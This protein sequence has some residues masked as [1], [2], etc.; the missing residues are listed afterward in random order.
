MNRTVVVAVCILFMFAFFV[1]ALILPGGN[2]EP[3]Q[4][5]NWKSAFVIWGTRDYS[6]E[7]YMGAD[8]EKYGSEQV[9]EEV[10]ELVVD[11]G[12]F[13]FSRNFWGRGT[14]PD[15]L[16]G[17]VSYCEQ[18]YNFTAVFYKGHSIGGYC[19]VENCTLGEHWMLYADG[20]YD[21]EW[22]N[23]WQIHESL[24]S[25]TH[26]FVFLW[27]CGY[28]SEERIG[29]IDENGHSVG[30]LTSWM[31]VTGLSGDGYA[32]PDGSSHCFIG[33]DD[34]SIWFTNKTGYN[35]FTYSDFA[36]LFFEYALMEG[37]TVND[38]LDASAEETHLQTSFG[39]CQLYTGYIMPDAENNG[40]PILCYMRVLGDGNLKLQKDDANSASLPIEENSAEKV[41]TYLQDVVGLDVPA[42]NTKLLGNSETYPEWLNGMPQQA[43]KIVLDSETSKLTVLYKLRNNSLSWCLVRPTEGTPHYIEQN[44][45][46]SKIVDG[47]LENY[48][49][50]SE[51]SDAQQM[52]SILNSVDF[53]QNITKTEGN[54]KL[55]VTVSEFSVS[56]EFTSAIEDGVL[57][58]SFRNGQVYAFKD[59]TAYSTGQSVD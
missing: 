50:Y 40:Q 45:E 38:A 58:A 9:C 1:S 3:S 26:D 20:G 10:L 42:Y 29:R 54:M 27:T 21:E 51:N 43:G 33:F 14:Q 30:M 16:Y 25:G 19:D 15:Q 24:S 47:F 55:A 31:N 49:T 59:T 2:Q 7:T 5:P 41:L 17:N 8:P 36:S 46:I 4:N 23:D 6:D 32:E 13:D 44:V 56:V 12:Q 22:I 52:R 37:W 53:T 39:D 11:S 57:V 35:D 48:Q 18:N 28:A 34:Y